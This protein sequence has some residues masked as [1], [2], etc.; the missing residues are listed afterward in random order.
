MVSTPLNI[1]KYVYK[2]GRSL[3][4][5]KSIHE[6]SVA[7]PDLSNVKSKDIYKYRVESFLRDC[8]DYRSALSLMEAMYDDNQFDIL[9]NTVNYTIN[10]IIPTVESS[11]LP[12]CI[13]K[14]SKAAIGD[15]NKDR[16]TEAAANFKSIDRIIKNHKTITKRFRVDSLKGKSE[17]D[18]VHT[19][20]EMVCTYGRPKYIN[21]N[22]A[23]E[24]CAYIESINDFRTGP[25]NEDRLV[26][27]ITDYFLEFDNNTDKDIQNYRKAI[28]ESKVLSNNAACLVPYLMDGAKKNGTWWDKLTEWKMDPDKSM[29]TIIELARENYSD[30]SAFGEIIN[31]AKDFARINEMDFNIA[32]VFSE[33][34]NPISR[35]QA[36]NILQV[37]KENNVKTSDDLVFS[38]RSIWEAEV[39][40]D[41]YY[42]DG[43]TVP[44]TF[45][46]DD[47][48]KFK[49]HNLITDAQD[50]GEFID[51]AMLTS[52]KESPVK[53]TDEG[54]GDIGK[55]NESNIID[56][57]D[58]EGYINIPLRHFSFSVDSDPNVAYKI[59]ESTA[60]CANNILANRNSMIYYAIED[61]HFSYSLKSKY[62]VVLS[63][64]QENKRGFTN[65]DKKKILYINRYAE[66]AQEISE[67]CIYDI[68]DNLKDNMNY[69]ANVS[70]EEAR[71]VA[72]IIKPYV[73]ESVLEEF[74]Y[75]CHHEG[76]PKADEI[77][78]TIHE[79]NTEFNVNAD[80]NARMNLC[81]RVMSMN[82]DA[83]ITPVIKKATSNIKKA[84]GI[85]SKDQ[86]QDSSDK[87]P[88]SVSKD[89]DEDKPKQNKAIKDES[90][91]LDDKDT[92]ESKKDENDDSEDGS[93]GKSV[94]SL[95]DAKLALKGLQAKGKDLSAKEQEA[96]RD[97]DME[98]NHLL[99]CIK[100]LYT[101]DHREEIITGEVN[102]SI[103]KILK[104]AIALAGAGVASGTIAVPAIGAVTL[105]AL[106]KHASKKEKQ[107]VLDQIDVELQ[108]LDREISR[109][110]SSGSAKKYRQL[111]MIQKNLQRKRQQI[112]FG[113]AKSGKRIPISSTAGLRE[114][115]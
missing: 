8:I 58:E 35:D 20:C 5:R 73:D 56:Y 2:R 13:A 78:K 70:V 105:F 85:K 88:A 103:S 46:S 4:R 93:Y 99:K 83:N 26:R 52:S 67:S 47:I 79:S 54:V 24:E 15:I 17:K 64:A 110:E 43:N 113:I 45:T 9:E 12:V 34:N 28:A 80:H 37:I 31:T 59:I 32:T 27:Y 60:K 25:M 39:N 6:N 72:D 87:K 40:D 63:E 48:D 77:A 23:L 96:S 10:N 3:E 91:D 29:E 107:A 90:D 41:S 66:A 106:S 53:I 65:F 89:L 101:T 38:L 44:Q 22:I 62:K 115:E 102:V 108:V 11:E 69:A 1:A 61:C 14:I 75:N 7:Y 111:L 81:A 42:A 92:K 30:I 76:N 112:H 18:R 84:V 71:L 36:K 21:F 104:I 74:I 51:H 57:I 55:V 95:N 98:F 109:A 97:L 100:S 82:E 33:F 94:K 49:M 68:I 16:L 114:R 86:K 19:V 50:A